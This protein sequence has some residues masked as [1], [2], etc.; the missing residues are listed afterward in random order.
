MK[1]VFADTLYWITSI[2]PDDPWKRPSQQARAALG[3]IRLVTTD[4]VL[5]EFLT[6]FAGRGAFL[7]RKACVTVQTLQQ[8]ETVVILPQTHF[9]FLKGF[10]LYESRDDE[11]YSLT[12]C[13]SMNV[14]RE[15]GIRDILTNDHH[16]TQEGFNI[17][18]HK[19]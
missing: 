18:I 13:I 9:S 8:D 17:L 6:S 7:R 15:E 12:D 5:V 3:K 4:E 11:Q 16:F 10:A 2:A 1:Q 19:E 14:M